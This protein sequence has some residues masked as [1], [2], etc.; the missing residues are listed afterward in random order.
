MPR[1]NA[2]RHF[3]A[4]EILY[5]GVIAFDVL[6]VGSMIFMPGGA[7]HPASGK[8]TGLMPDLSEL[9]KRGHLDLAPGVSPVL[10]GALALLA[11]VVLLAGIAGI[12]LLIWACVRLARRK[13]LLGQHAIVETGW[14]LWDVLKVAAFYPFLLFVG[15][16][17]VYWIPR[18]AG[19]WAAKGVLVS[20]A[21]SCFA[22]AGALLVLCRVVV[23]ERGQ[24][25]QALGWTLP[26]GFRD[27]GRVAGCYA[28]LQP[29]FFG[30]LLIT[31]GIAVC[32]GTKP[33]PQ[34][35]VLEFMSER[36]LSVTLAI[37]AL[38]CVVAPIWEETLFRGF[39]QPALRRLVGQRGAILLTALVFT[40]AHWSLSV[41]LPIFVL[42]LMLGYLYE[43]TQS[44]IASALLHSVHN[45]MTSCFLLL[46]KY[47]PVQ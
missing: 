45:T 22:W 18:P 43:K 39:L 27:V 17:V 11:V 20:L 47:L 25:L 2:V 42:G 26:G 10:V 8:G 34:K 6:A 33:V 31:Q 28:A 24:S 1:W 44:T 23:K 38:A 35:I 3:V 46:V 15:S 7:T 29:L 41:S 12:G 36:S 4:R 9:L 37:L 40:C 30:S 5:I 16:C 19:G 14:T 21:V 13:P 32:V